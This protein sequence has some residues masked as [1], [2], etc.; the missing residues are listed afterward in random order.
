[1]EAKAKKATA[2]PMFECKCGEN[3]SLRGMFTRLVE[4]RCGRRYIITPRPGTL[5]DVD[6]E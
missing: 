1:M 3:V 2:H 6:E 4:C 5:P